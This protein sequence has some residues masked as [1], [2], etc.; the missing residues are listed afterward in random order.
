MRNFHLQ[1]PKRIKADR[2]LKVYNQDRVVIGDKRRNIYTGYDVAPGEAAPV[3]MPVPTKLMWDDLVAR[4]SGTPPIE[5]WQYVEHRQ[6]DIGRAIALNRH[7]RRRYESKNGDIWTF[8]RYTP[9]RIDNPYYDPNFATLPYGERMRARHRKIE[10]YTIKHY[11]VNWNGVLP[12][13]DADSSSSSFTGVDCFIWAVYFIVNGSP[14]DDS[15][16]PIPSKNPS[17]NNLGV[18]QFVP[19]Y[20]LIIE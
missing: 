16:F 1:I 18:G 4:Y 11:T 17:W 19:D 7:A 5:H 3:Y 8:N 14:D 20:D 15:W 6:M 12:L 13:P 10:S 2:K 9:V